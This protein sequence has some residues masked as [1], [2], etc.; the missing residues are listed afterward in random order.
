MRAHGIAHRGRRIAEITDHLHVAGDEQPSVALLHH[1]RLA[2][3]DAHA[4]A[5]GMAREEILARHVIAPPVVGR[6][7][8]ARI[9]GGQEPDLAFLRREQGERECFRHRWAADAAVRQPRN[10]L[11]PGAA[12]QLG[13]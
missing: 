7:A 9:R 4:G 3:L 12:R 5:F 1:H 11:E 13:D 2:H 8:K 10:E 6:V